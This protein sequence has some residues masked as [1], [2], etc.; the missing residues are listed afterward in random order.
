MGLFGT[1]IFGAAIVAGVELPGPM[2]L[3]LAS[4]GWITY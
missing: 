2:M 3:L 4:G 1:Y